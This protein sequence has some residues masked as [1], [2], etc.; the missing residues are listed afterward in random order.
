[1]RISPLIMA[2]RGIS[3]CRQAH[4]FQGFGKEMAFGAQSARDKE[5]GPDAGDGIKEGGHLKRMECIE[6]TR[7]R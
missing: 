4:R 6:G 1:M 7:R 2:R 3:F 5:A